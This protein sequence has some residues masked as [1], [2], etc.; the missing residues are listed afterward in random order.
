MERSPTKKGQEIDT[1]TKK[2]EDQV[3]KSDQS[4]WEMMIDGIVRPPRAKY[5]TNQLGNQYFILGGKFFTYHN[6]AYYREEH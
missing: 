3:S 6:K 2:T 1:K 4:Y 5:Q